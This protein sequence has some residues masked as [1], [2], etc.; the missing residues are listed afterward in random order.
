MDNELNLL[1]GRAID[2]LA[3]LMLL[4]YLDGNRDEVLSPEAVAG[5]VG[6]RP[7]PVAQ[8]LKELAEAGLVKRFAVGTGR[9][10]LYSASE[11]AHVQSLIEAL[12]ARYEQDEESRAEI[13]RRVVPVAPEPDERPVPR[14]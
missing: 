1:L 12:R 9:I 8:A 3:K 5:R 10:L 14:V 11:D 7:E 4:F 6:R 2:S 13:V